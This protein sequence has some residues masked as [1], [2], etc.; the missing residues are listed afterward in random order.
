MQRF[1]EA[2]KCYDKAIEYD[3][4]VNT[5]NIENDIK[6]KAK[7]YKGIAHRKI[8]EFGQSILILK[9]AV[10]SKTDNPEAHN[11]LGL[12]YFEQKSYED[13]K[14]SFA[15]AIALVNDKVEKD[16]TL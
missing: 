10:D 11:N 1:K 4:G 2:I 9:E 13:A 6:Y 7:F 5:K 14:N 15:K 3:A 16:P 8:N 12:S